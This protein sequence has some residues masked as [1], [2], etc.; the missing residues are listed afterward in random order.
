MAKAKATKEPAVEK[1]A[2]TT[3]AA[4]APVEA[5]PRNPALEKAIRDEPDDD[6][7][8]TVYGD[9]L[10]EQGHPRGELATAQLTRNA[11]AAKKLLDKQ[12]PAL[13]GGLAGLKDMVTNVVWRGGFIER[14]RVANVF[15]RSKLHSGEKESV[16]VEKIVADLLSGPGRFLREL[17]VGIADYEGNDYNGVID[18]IVA[19]KSVPTLR[20][21]FFGDFTSEETELNWS[22]IGDIG[23]L[24]KVLPKLARLKLRSGGMKWKTALDF[25]SMRDIIVYSGGFDDNAAKLLA[26]AKWPK[27][28]KLDLMIGGK[29]YGGN[30]KVASLQPIFDAKA[31]PKLVNLGIKNFEFHKDLLKPLFAS[32]VLRQLKILDLSMGTL[33]DSEADAFVA[34]KA[35]LAHLEELIV[36]ENYF[37]A[38]GLKK[39]RGLDIKVTTKGVT[40]GTRG[41][42]ADTNGLGQ[43]D[44]E[45]PE[46]DG[47]RYASVYE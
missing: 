5:E 20:S 25:P 43:R 40:G 23:K 33:G 29:N 46:D 45:D 18:A 4:P 30:A 31:V 19:Q 15:E 41:R 9:W 17:T 24:S 42:Y 10:T 8:Y 12:T 47:D 26:A 39:L 22:A 3:K 34:A 37:T 7:A 27:L 13:W 35:Q 2:K 16:D 36:A 28:E 6:G 11:A 21:I 14:A 1:P 44:Q 38:A 32:K